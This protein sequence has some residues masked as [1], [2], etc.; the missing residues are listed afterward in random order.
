MR[1]KPVVPR[2][3]AHRDIEQ[4]VACYLGNE[5]EHAALG[6]IDALE[7][8]FARLSRQPGIGSPRYAHE[9]G[10]PDLRCGQI[11]RYPHLIFYAEAADRIDVWRVLH[12]QRGLPALMQQADSF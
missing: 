11:E 3:Q 2:E 9:L 10:L 12:G 6:F 8:A 7:L 5:A 4:I 1:T